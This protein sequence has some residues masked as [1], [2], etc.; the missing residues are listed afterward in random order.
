MVS[1]TYFARIH[2]RP[3]FQISKKISH[4]KEDLQLLHKPPMSSK[5]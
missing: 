2:D 5:T 3:A 1:R 4:E